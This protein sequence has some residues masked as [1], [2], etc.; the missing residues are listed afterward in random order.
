MTTAVAPA[1]WFAPVPA[2]YTE[3]VLPL[4]SA[5]GGL[6]DDSRGE[7]WQLQGTAAINSSVQLFS[8]DTLDADTGS[9][10]WVDN[11]N[12]GNPGVTDPDF[13]FGS[14]DH[15][16]EGWFYTTSTGST[17]YIHGAGNS[18]DSM[19]NTPWLAYL[20]GGNLYLAWVENASSTVY[21]TN[22]GAVSGSTWYHYAISRIGN[23]LYMLFNGTLKGT[24][25]VTGKSIRAP[26]GGRTVMLGQYAG[27][28]R[29]RGRIGPHRWTNGLGRYSADY[30]P[31][32]APF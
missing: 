28:N 15:T 24:H 12:G 20:F 21:E 25:D 9:F 5:S 4:T 26:A 30:T 22:C 3:V 29:T 31:P 2:A 7:P 10:A 16:I 32:S 19:T 6:T 27:V 13:I 23:N 8:L 1:F 11:L 17:Q 18:L 14:G